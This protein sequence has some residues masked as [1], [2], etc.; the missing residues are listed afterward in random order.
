MQQQVR[1]KKC[2]RVLTS[3][4]SIAMGMGP[5]C[6]GVIGGGKSVRVRAG[7][8]CGTP[9]SLGTSSGIQAIFPTGEIKPKRPSKKE[10]ARRNREERRRLFDERLP[11]QCGLLLPERKPI[12]YT[13]TEDGAWKDSTSGRVI[14]HNQLQSYLKR[15]Q[16]I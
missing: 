2:G 1:C 6:A 11:F 10:I 14:P 4:S 12:I 16:F 8:R 3:P 5:K 15:Y 9:Y 13:P 7:R